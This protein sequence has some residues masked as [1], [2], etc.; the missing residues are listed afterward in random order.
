[1]VYF[2]L[3]FCLAT[4]IVLRHFASNDLG[5]LAQ[6]PARSGLWR[7]P[8]ESSNQNPAVWFYSAASRR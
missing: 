6:V 7:A 2:V 4:S 3:S 1:M 5:S 8:T